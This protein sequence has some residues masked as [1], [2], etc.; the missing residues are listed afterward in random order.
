[1]KYLRPSQGF[2]SYGK[3]FV[4][5]LLLFLLS[6]KAI[7]Q[8]PGCPNVNA[9]TDVTIDCTTNACTDLTATFLNTGETNSYDVTSIPYAPPHPFIG[10]ANAIGVGTDDIWSG[11]INLPF[12]FCFFESTYNQIQVGSNGVLRFDVDANDTT[13]EW[14][15][16][17]DIPNNVNLALAEANIFGVSHDIDPSVLSTNPEIAW[18]VIG[19]APCRTFVLSFANVANFSCNDLIST[20]QIILYE[21][22]NAIEIYVKD[23]PSCNTWNNGNAILG[24]Q[25]NP[26]DTAFTA[27]GRNTSDSPWTAT[28]EAWRFTPN[29]TPNYVLT[30]FDENGTNLGN[31]PTIN[32]CPT[33]TTTYTS[34]VTYT[35]CNGNVIEVEDEVIVTS[36]NPTNPNAGT[37][38]AIA[39]CTDDTS[40]INLFDSLGG[41][42]DTGGTWSPT[43]NSGTGIFNPTID[44]AGTYIY[45]VSGAPCPDNTANVTVSLSTPVN[46]GTDGTLSICNSNNATIDL[47][48]LLGNNPDYGGAWTPVLNSGTSIFDPTIDPFGTYTYSVT[49]IT[50]CASD[51]AEVVL[52]SN[53]QPNAGI[54]GAETICMGDT[55]TINLFDS[56][57]GNPDTG[58]TWNPPLNSGTDIFDPAIDPAGTYTY[59]IT[60][61]APCIDNTANVVISF[62]TPANAGTNGSLLICDSSSSSTDLF[63][64]LGNNPDIGGTWTPTLNSGTGVFDPTIDTPGTYTYSVTGNSPCPSDTAEVIVSSNSQP[65][66]G[67]DGA[68]TI[69]MGDTTTINLFDSL[70]GNPDTGGTWNPPLNSGTDI[71]DPAIDPAGTYTYSITGIAPCIDNTANVVISFST[72]ANAGTNGSL[73]ICDSSSSST[74]LFTLLGNNPDIGGTWTPTLNSGTGVFDPTIDT[75]GTYIY[76][77]TGNSPCPS[78]TAEV[79]VSSNNQPNAG[80]DGA[81]TI[82]MGDTTIINLFDSLG[83]TPDTGGTWNPPLNSGT[84]IFDPTIDPAGTYVYTISNTPCPVDTA[85]VIISFHTPVNAG[86]DGSLTTC[87]DNNTII[88]LFTLLG[89]NPDS[90]GTWSP[91]LN[92]G[93]GIF[94]SAIDSEGTYTYTLDGISPCPSD[95]AEVTITLN[96]LPIVLQP[97]NLI[98]CDLNNDNVE[99]FDLEQQT[100]FI[101]ADNVNHTVTYHISQLDA[102]NGVNNL[103]SPYNNITNPQTI[104]SRVENINTNCINT[105]INFDLVLNTT[106]I[107]N[108]DSYELCDDDLET[109]NDSANDSTIFNLQSRDINILGPNQTATG[110]T[111]TYY[112]NQNDANN[113]LNPLPSNY[114][115]VINPQIIYARV[116]NNTTSCFAISEV[117]LIVNPLPFFEL[118]NKYAFCIDNNGE[119]I[120]PFPVIDTNLDN[121]NYTFEWYINNTLITGETN[122]NI[123]PIQSGIYSVI[124]TNS[125]TNCS[126]EQNTEVIENM[127]PSIELQQAS[128]TF[129]ENNDVLAT[130]TNNGSTTASYEFSLNNGP[131]VTN[132]TNTYLF[133]DVPAG[134]HVISVR[135]IN[136]CGEASSSI[137]LLDFIP[138]FTPNGDGFHDTWN[139]IGI[140]N[141]PDAV[142][143]IFNRYGK[144]LK[145]LDPTGEGWNGTYNNYV[146]P[147]SDYW[148][149]L[150]YKDPNTNEPKS[151]K[152][153]FTLKH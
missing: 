109:D 111:V 79:I 96:S 13:N 104:Y 12:D 20:S 138:Y 53:S 94:D 137:I 37:D 10:L 125:N 124:V 69:C 35:N 45:S 68:E 107:A 61:I 27:P 75:P 36:N 151:F 119:V 46:A 117:Q 91:P 142:I 30:W 4:A 129:I 87:D 39:I 101:I 93:T 15:Y 34:Q 126:Y 14:Q 98:L 52:I 76:S 59:S 136:G 23:K 32:V 3:I 115:N 103:I 139:I 51:T 43:L 41:T 57:G 60:G 141:Q 11:I 150:S 97:D 62:S 78:D 5:T 1:M 120:L 84:D 147:S 9:G 66:A 110:F 100:D 24:I 134:E 25:N 118:D 48:T 18:E 148:F 113:S 82:C 89:N 33:I 47:F 8:G 73:L 19:A 133:E 38:G 2:Y 65:N 90:G 56:L 146:L 80:I 121:T 6:L 81:E 145:Q 74:D 16:T 152:S 122:S 106:V 63:T 99:A 149:S 135:D 71:F 102:N 144:L 92:S 31:T 128:V 153:H 40:T 112:L 140:E 22:T 58:G 55:T 26:G 123:T 127:I 130:A 108:P 105:S 49:G 114:E 143:Y 29:G 28:N 44:P 88:D 83:G 64:L 70:G 95:A 17:E 54:D 67:I 85:N 131:W 21:T 50:P 72:P 77:V 86:T 116:E 42:P 7:S 132:G